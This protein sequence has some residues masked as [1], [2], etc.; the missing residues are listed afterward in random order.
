VTHYDTNSI[1]AVDVERRTGDGKLPYVADY[2][3][4]TITA[5]SIPS[6]LRDAEA[7]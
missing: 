1:P 4:G 5:N 7:V 3:A 6:A 2:W